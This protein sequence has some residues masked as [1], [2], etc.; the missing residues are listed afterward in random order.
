MLELYLKY[1]CYVEKT[2]KSILILQNMDYNTKI[3][4]KDI[5]I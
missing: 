4:E 1:E 2:Q 3:F 5:H